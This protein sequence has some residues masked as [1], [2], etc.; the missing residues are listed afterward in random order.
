MSYHAME[1]HINLGL[2]WR[3]YMLNSGRVKNKILNI[4]GKLS[5]YDRYHGS[6]FEQ[7]FGCHGKVFDL[8]KRFV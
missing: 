6:D 1:F 8:S 4:T 7:P 2:N 3:S 5:K